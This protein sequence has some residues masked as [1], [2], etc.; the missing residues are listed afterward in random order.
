MLGTGFEIPIEL[1]DSGIV[2]VL[3]VGRKN[4]V[5]AAENSILPVNERAVTI[6]GENFKSVEVEHGR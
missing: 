5:Q 3:A 6:E 1:Q 2:R 4:A